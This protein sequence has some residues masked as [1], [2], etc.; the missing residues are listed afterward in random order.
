M[1]RTSDAIAFIDGER[2]SVR[3]GGYGGAVTLSITATDRV[4]IRTTKPKRA[5]REVGPNSRVLREKAVERAE[6]IIEKVR[7]Q[8]R[9]PSR[10]APARPAPSR[11]V[12]I[13][14]VWIENIRR[15]LGVVPDRIL[16]MGRQEL[17]AFYTSLT[18]AA[19]RKMPFDTLNGIVTASRHLNKHGVAPF[20]ADIGDLDAGDLDTWASTAI[21]RGHLMPSSVKS[22]LGRFKTAVRAFRRRWRKVWGARLD[23]TEFLEIIEDDPDNVPEI[24]EENAVRLLKVLETICWRAFGTAMIAHETARRVGA[25]GSA[26]PGQHLDTLPLTA[27]DLEW[28]DD[29]TLWIRWR[30]RAQK[31][32]NFGR[33]NARTKASAGAHR[34]LAW[35]IREH[36]NPH[37]T[38]GP[39]IWSEANPWRPESYD[40]LSRTFKIAWERA[41][42]EPKPR[43]LSW[44]SFCRTTITTIV[45]ETGSVTAAAEYTGRTAGVIEKHYKKA[46]ESESVKT[47]AVLDNARALSAVHRG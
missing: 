1:E 36:P 26:R 7:G 43:Y 2:S 3:L 20:M 45:D 10:P 44:H 28:M 24:G 9:A 21:A 33:G 35:L 38:A 11:P 37:G 42:S 32:G 15:K 31:G 46:R 17:L 22:Y 27:D 19:R 5:Q 40:R 12:T 13:E 30:A 16:D 8:K 47:A 23:P 4:L 34:V 39:L 6:S 41:F 18:P 25:I 29:G 14:M